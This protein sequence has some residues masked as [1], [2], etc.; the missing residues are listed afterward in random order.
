MT[1][2]NIFADK[3]FLSWNI[4]DFNW[5][6]GENC[7]PPEK[8]YPSFPATPSKSW[9]PVKPPPFWK[10]GWRFTPPAERGGGGWV[11][12]TIVNKVLNKEILKSAIFITKKT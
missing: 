3:F 4:S 12:H 5:F 7:K 6:F 2:K 9:S 11:M 8:I 10:F 1:E